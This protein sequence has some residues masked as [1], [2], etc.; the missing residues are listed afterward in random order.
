MA[1][2]HKAREILGLSGLSGGIIDHCITLDQAGIHFLKSEYAQ[3]RSINNHIA[4]ITSTDLNAEAYA[5]ALL[6]IAEINAMTGVDEQDVHQNLDYA[7]TLFNEL[8]FLHGIIY[9][10]TILADLDLR[11][12]RLSSAS[13]LFCKYLRQSW[14]LHGDIISYCLER[15][16]NIS[17]WNQLKFEG[18]IMW[19]VI[20]LV[21]AH[22]SKDSLGLHK[23]LLFLGDVFID[24]KDEGTASNLYSVA[25][26]GLTYMDIHR[27][28]AQCMLRLGDLAKKRGEISK[29]TGF[30]KAAR[31]LF[32][33]SLQAKDVSQIDTRLAAVSQAHQ[34]ALEHLTTLHTSVQLLQHL[35]IT[36]HEEKSNIEEVEDGLHED[37]KEGLV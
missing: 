12:G 4:E 23:A 16:A 26:E 8:K 9:C 36:N 11:E 10:E 37:A 27:S 15:L 6:N 13:T 24:G 7:R 32:E 19:P 30:W 17:Q 22:K 3:A 2:S 28:R 18:N 35:S 25:L 14:G 5:Y 29:A 1:Q 21:Y 33:R 20:Y 34:E 31:P